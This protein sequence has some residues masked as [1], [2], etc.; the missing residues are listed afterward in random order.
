[1]GQ[2]ANFFAEVA[3]DY[4]LVIREPKELEYIL[5]QEFGAHVRGLYEKTSSCDEVLPVKLIKDMRCLATSRQN[6]DC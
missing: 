5:E 6:A 4:E 1:M 3:N 2:Q